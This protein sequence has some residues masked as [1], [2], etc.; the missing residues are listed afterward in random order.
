[1]NEKSHAH[2]AI[3]EASEAGTPAAPWRVREARACDAAAIC[4]INRAALGY[5]CPEAET[6]AQLTLLLHSA[7]N[8]LWVAENAGDVLGYI[9][10][11]DYDTVYGGCQK[12]ILAL[13]VDPVAQGRGI[14]RALLAAAED[15]AG[16]S[17]AIGMRLVSGFD[18]TGAHRF[19]L[20]CGY[21]MRKE[22]KNF[23]KRW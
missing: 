10:A 2:D 1:M 12:N 6:R 3:I 18:R 13:A 4:R 7:H 11:A 21:R 15:W 16:K 23:V 14:G 8:R 20:A 17:G 5:D 19:Y 22:Q 9:H